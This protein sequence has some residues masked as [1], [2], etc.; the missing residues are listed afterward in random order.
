LLRR[1][2]RGEQKRRRAAETRESG[3]AAA[4]AALVDH[5]DL[6]STRFPG[7]DQYFTSQP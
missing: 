2:G 6:L 5:L 7:H 4:N 1:R 3:K